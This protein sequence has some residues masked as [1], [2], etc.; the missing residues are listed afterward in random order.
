MKNIS[1]RLVC[2]LILLLVCIFAGCSK[3]SDKTDEDIEKDNAIINGSSFTHSV[4]DATGSQGGAI[5]VFGENTI[6]N[7]SSFD[8]ASAK[9][10]GGAIYIQGQYASVIDSTFNNTI[11][12]SISF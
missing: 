12:K 11:T 9:A 3:E 4:V 1:N 6:I 2:V 5:Y 7:G 10:Q 8:D